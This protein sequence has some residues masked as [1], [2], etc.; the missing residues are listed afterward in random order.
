MRAT[1]TYGP[2]TAGGWVA[3]ALVAAMVITPLATKLGTDSAGWDSHPI[4]SDGRSG[5]YTDLI[6]RP[7]TGKGWHLGRPEPKPSPKPALLVRVTRDIQVKAHPAD[8]SS[9]IGVVPS[10]SK[11]Y[12]I[13]T[14]AWV[15][16][17]SPDGK[18]GQVQIPYVSP[19]RN[20]WIRLEGLK[21]ARTWFAV[22]VDLSAHRV[23]VTKAGRKLFSFPAAIGSPTSPTPPGRYFVSDR[24][25]FWRGSALGSFAFGI[26]GI[27]PRL[28]IGWNGGN[29]LAIH[30]TN[31]M[32]LIGTSSSAGCV[33]VSEKALAE[34][35]PLLLLGTPVIISA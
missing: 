27:Q 13:P 33:R 29:Q 19:R 20:G 7:T 8:G 32:S 26:S 21:R 16:K 35:K 22:H 10:G 28:P 30:G 6:A 12:R 5:P 1:Q 3:V 25:P 2:N 11:Y 31:D 17:V 18:W 34:M 23:T 4:T 14:T 15:L 9:V 24:I